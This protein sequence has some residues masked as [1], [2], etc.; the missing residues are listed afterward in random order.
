[1]TARAVIFGC[2]GP[3]LLPEEAAF[4]RDAGPW[5]FI[6][7]ARNIKTP[8]QTIELVDSLRDSV[9]R[10]SAPVLIDQEGGRVSRLTAPHWRTA[11][12]AEK[13][14]QLYERQNPALARQAC[15][16]NGRLLAHELAALGIT[17]DCVPV[18]D[19]PAPGGHQIIG[20]RA[21]ASD[22]AIV[23]ELGRALCEGLMAGGVLPVIKHIPGHGRAGADS[24]L[25]LPQV[26]ASL[27]ELRRSD[28]APFRALRDMPLAMTAHVAYTAIDGATPASHS[29]K[30]IRDIIRGEIGFNGVLM[31]DDLGMKALTGNFA[32]R[33]AKAIAAGCDMLL[34]CSGVMTEMRE[35]LRETPMLSGQAM[36]RCAAALA[37]LRMPDKFDAVAAKAQLDG[38]L[39]E[40]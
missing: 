40:M 31:C 4:L 27:D 12:A 5:G 7:F 21:F 8:E 29:A 10:P 30:I 26:S 34:H 2:S 13:F 28:F 19:V 9:G 39:D 3:E 16:L 22:P 1:M 35:V 15:M 33:A 38:L 6:L 25:D 18:L 37:H 24:H 32:E 36:V 23:A 14:G 17:V 20:D 11:P